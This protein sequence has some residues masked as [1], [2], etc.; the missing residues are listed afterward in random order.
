MLCR[1]WPSLPQLGTSYSISIV[2]QSKYHA[3]KRLFFPF[4]CRFSSQ[5]LLVTLQKLVIGHVGRFCQSGTSCTFSVVFRPKY[6]ASRGLSFPLMRCRCRRRLRWFGLRG[7]YDSFFLYRRSA[8]LQPVF[9]SRRHFLWV[10]VRCHGLGPF[11]QVCSCCLS[12]VGSDRFFS[13]VPVCQSGFLV[14]IC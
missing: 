14:Q 3:S 6:Q 13:T 9:L 10:P 4:F 8:R 11:L 2:L 7:G 5:F 12:H 1:R